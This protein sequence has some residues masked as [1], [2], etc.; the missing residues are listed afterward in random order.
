MR[1]RRLRAI[2]PSPRGADSLAGIATEATV[3]RSDLKKPYAMRSYPS[4]TVHR[5][6]S[7][8]PPCVW[9]VPGARVPS[10]RVRTHQTSEFEP[11]LTTA[12]TT[13]HVSDA[14]EMFR[15]RRSNLG[16]SQTLWAQ[17]AHRHRAISTCRCTH[18]APL[19]RG[20]RGEQ[21]GGPLCAMYNELQPAIASY[22]VLIAIV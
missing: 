20:L 13:L 17:L 18:R 5:A 10:L 16:F 3:G 8:A 15:A 11:R 21:V 22:N 9:G 12:R 2:E 19:G 7:L 6:C 1:L 4:G 14:S